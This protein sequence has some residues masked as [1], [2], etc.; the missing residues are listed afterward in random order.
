MNPKHPLRDTSKCYKESPLGRNLNANPSSINSNPN[1]LKY[2]EPTSLDPSWCQA[3][4][5]IILSLPPV[6]L[7]GRLRQVT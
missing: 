1:S 3:S 4:K 5:S 2:R 7:E 6:A